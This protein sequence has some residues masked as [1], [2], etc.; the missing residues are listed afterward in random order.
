MCN[1]MPFYVF[2][3]DCSKIKAK[4]N[5]K[6]I[7]LKLYKKMSLRMSKYIYNIY[8]YIYIYSDPQLNKN[9]SLCL[10]TTGALINLVYRA[11][12]LLNEHC[13]TS[14]LI[15]LCIIIYYS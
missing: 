2:R 4:T 5:I 11:L 3:F 15:A 12:H 13:A 1:K 7:N 6:K 14:K 10:K 8:I 9:K